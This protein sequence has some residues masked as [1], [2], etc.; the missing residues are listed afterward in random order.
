MEL[1][2]IFRA[3]MHN[4]SRF[5][6]IAVEVALTLAIVTNCI[7]IML[8]M[9]GEFLKPSGMDEDNLLVVHTEPFAPEFKDEEFV[10]ALREEDLLKLRSFPGVV[11]ASGFHQIPLSGS[12]S[13]TGRR[14]AESELETTV[15]PMFVV[16]DR[17]LQTLGVELIE[18]R[19]FEAVDFDY[20]NDTYEAGQAA[21]SV[22]LNQALAK[23][24]FPNE[25]SVGKVIQNDSGDRAE[26]VIGVVG[27]LL[28]SWPTSRYGE[29]TM[30][31]PGKPGNEYRMRYLVRTEPGAVDSVY[32][33]LENLMRNTEP[34]RVITIR[35]IEEVKRGTFTMHLALIR[36]LTVVIFLLVV[37]TSIGIVGL[38]S[39]SVTE[40]TRQIGTR[41]ALGA[42][43]GDIVRH[44]LVENWMITGFGLALGLALTIG[45]NFTLTNA[46]DA[47]KMDWYLLVGGPLLLW[48]TGIVAALLPAIRASRV[49]P[50]IATRT[51]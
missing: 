21:R 12:G 2:P 20:D 28:N 35:T 11:E 44:F 13:A 50:E 6:L 27:T 1:G 41:R 38:T 46:A 31:L 17:A 37:V 30:L 24:L 26:T 34:G 40:R 9:R 5:W 16:T 47:P 3:L 7:N 32:S 33:E 39:F 36:I 49:T 42:T 19:D 25:T 23:K 45:L 22:I 48:A 4:K 10:D 18:G 8:D 51:V 14:P 29:D 15:A 43:R